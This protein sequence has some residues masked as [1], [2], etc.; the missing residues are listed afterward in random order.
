MVEPR[1]LVGIFSTGLWRLRGLEQLLDARGLVFRPG[2]AAARQL[3]AVAGWGHKPTAATARAYAERHGLP[4]LG[5][6]DGFLR[7]VGLGASEPPLSLIVDDLGIYY[8][9]RVPSR[10]ERLFETLADGQLEDSAVLQR[11]ARCRQLIVDGGISK[12]NHAPSE[13]P[14]ELADP[15][16]LIIVADQTYDD[17]SVAGALADA[18]S[19]D[20]ALESALREHPQAKVVVKVHPATVA[21][22]KRGYLADRVSSGRLVVVGADL[23]PYALL[24]RARHL[25]VVSSQLGFE[26]LLAGVPVTCFGQP[27]YAG[28]G[29]TDD[30][31]SCP[32][33][34]R[35]LSL[36]QLVAG[37]L[38]LYPRYRDPLTAEPCEAERVIEHLALQRR[39]FDEN[40]R[41]FVCFDMS[42]WKRPFV[43][44]YLRAPG[45]KVRFVSSTRE[46]AGETDPSQLTVVVWASRKS[47]TLTSWA[48][49]QRVPLWCMED[50]FLRSAGLGSDLT[51]PGS[52]VLDP[53]GIY[54]DPSRPSRLEQLLQSSAFSAEELERARRLR[55]Q[56]VASKISKYNLPAGS[57][58]SLA[59]RPGQRILFV[60]GQVADDASVR[61]GTQDVSDNLSL[62]QAVRREH[63]DAYI[64]YKP[65]PDVQSGNRV[66]G[67]HG[68][69]TPPWDLVIGQVPIATCLAA[70]DEVHTMTSLVGFEALLRGLPVV[71]YGQPFYAGW[72]LTRDLAPVTRRTRHLTLDELVAGVLLRY[73]RY[74]SWET[75]CFCSAEDKVRELAR[76][77]GRRALR[78]RLPRLAI[79][80][81]SLAASG[82]EWWRGRELRRG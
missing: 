43:R 36:E 11:A 14:P 4:Y 40:R 48:A 66:G 79:K 42:Y 24:R 19:F 21:G 81:S 75:G 33:R 82:L 10:L 37:A 50:G 51:A 38:M 74:V 64:I 52:L 17:A 25:Y 1:G 71:T 20:R 8:D 16:D 27:F 62:L 31:Q 6:E 77:Q 15:E 69:S 26:G 55:E 35:R 78:V 28:W 56:V 76:A 67:L 72:G 29:L 68:L 59:V 3:S 41:H 73:P 23:N 61:L 34:T 7:S 13:L 22:K 57:Q 49:A 60:P 80:L 18:S 9:A 12:Y 44:R 63:P 54:Y 39:L 2:A 32:R 46:L 47:A 70:A 53:D 5:L 45:R 58:L 65:H 30:R